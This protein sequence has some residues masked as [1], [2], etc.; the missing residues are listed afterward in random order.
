MAPHGNGQIPNVHFHKDWQRYIRVWFDQPMR[1]KRRH[2]ARV[3]KARRIAPRPLK[4]LQPQ[5]H[6]E[7]TKYNNKVRL[8]RGFTRLEV[9]QAGISPNFAR[10]IGIRVDNRRRNKSNEGLQ[11]NVARL[12]AYM[13]KLV[14]FPK[15]KKPRKGE[16]D[17]EARKMATQLVGEVMPLKDNSSRP[18]E[19]PRVPT[20]PEK[21]VKAYHIIQVARANKRLKGRRK[22]ARKMRRIS[23]E[24]KLKERDAK[25]KE[26]RKARKAAR[27][28]KS[29]SKPAA[30]KPA[31]APAKKAA[32]KKK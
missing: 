4:K 12:K 15:G 10:T 19:P 22:L 28:S 7:Y 11:A 23:L 17:S 26:K 16:A 13:A 25:L 5:V 18:E 9:G 21:Q 1:K 2:A 31:A 3:E 14:L 30:S 27:K 20:E 8:G 29:P 32:P 6:C 24:A